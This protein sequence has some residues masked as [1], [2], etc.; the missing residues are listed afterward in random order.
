MNIIVNI[1]IWSIKSK[2]VVKLSR[3]KDTNVHDL[4]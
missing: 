4:E 3:S 2:A 1:V